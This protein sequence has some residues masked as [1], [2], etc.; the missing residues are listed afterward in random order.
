VLPAVGIAAV[1]VA[2]N[3]RRDRLDRL[4]VATVLELRVSLELRRLFIIT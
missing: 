4:V 1:G 3:G 2:R